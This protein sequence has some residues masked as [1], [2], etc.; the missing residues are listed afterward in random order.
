MHRQKNTPKFQIKEIRLATLSC[1][2]FTS[3]VFLAKT[4]LRINSLSAHPNQINQHQLLDYNNICE[5]DWDT[6]IPSYGF[7]MKF[8]NLY[9][10][11][12]SFMCYWNILRLK[13]SCYIHKAIA[14][15]QISWIINPDFLPTCWT[16]ISATPYE[17]CDTSTTNLM[18]TRGMTWFVVL[19]IIRN[20]ANFALQTIH[21]FEAL[22]SVWNIRTQF[23]LTN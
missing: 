13:C 18:S 17:F 3:Q 23:L 14:D 6:Y 19:F 4:S 9:H 11:W 22:E 7:M 2:W 5:W 15:W 10:N 20:I 12:H 1:W 21:C 8:A 16:T